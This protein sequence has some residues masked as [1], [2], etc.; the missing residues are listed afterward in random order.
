MIK[1]RISNLVTTQRTQ[2]VELLKLCITFDDWSLFIR[3]EI[4]LK[5]VTKRLA[6]KENDLEAAKSELIEQKLSAI[7]QK[8][9]WLT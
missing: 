5:K 2:L 6:D 9:K 8:N 3:Q 7:D 4:E 1:N